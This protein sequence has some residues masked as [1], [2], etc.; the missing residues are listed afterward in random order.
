MQ[1]RRATIDDARS[2]TDLHLDVW[3]EA[4][5]G[6]LPRQVL[7]ARRADPEARFER[8]RR[9]L[10]ERTTWVLDDPARPGRL[11]G[12]STGGERRDDDATLPERELWAC[13]VRAE[14]YDTG[15]GHALLVAAIGD[16]PAY[17]WVLDGNKRAIRF[18]EKHG[19]ALDGATKA[20]FERRELRMVR[21]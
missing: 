20:A 3:D 9:N 21:R 5:A 18:Y 16:E 6:L 11:L 2:L 4:Y 1:V 12:F 8:W 15:A 7:D 13:Y 17:L 14:I 10:A 19:F